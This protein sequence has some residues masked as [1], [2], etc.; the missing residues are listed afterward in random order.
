M[1]RAVQ[2]CAVYMVVVGGTFYFSS[3]YEVLLLFNV[4]CG[5]FLCVFFFLSLFLILCYSHYIAGYDSIDY[6]ESR[7]DGFF[8]FYFIRRLSF[9]ICAV[10]VCD[11]CFVCGGVATVCFLLLDDRHT[12]L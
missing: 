4:S 8:V 5:L 12:I 11:E 7:N 2:L 3:L 9:D 10:N 1:I 6:K